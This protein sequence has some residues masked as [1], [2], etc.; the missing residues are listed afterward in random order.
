MTITSISFLHN[1]NRLAFVMEM[2]GVLTM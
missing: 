1:I 2:Q